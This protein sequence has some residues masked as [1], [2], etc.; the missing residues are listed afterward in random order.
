VAG[1]EGATLTMGT[2][3]SVDSIY[4]DMPQVIEEISDKNDKRA[5]LTDLAVGLIAEGGLPTLTYRSLASAANVSV[6][7]IQHEFSSREEILEATFERAWRQ[8]GLRPG[9]E[10]A[11]SPR[12]KLFEIC[13][14]AVPVE[15][16]PDPNIRAYFEL[17][18]EASRDPQ[19]KEGIEAVEL[20]GEKKYLRLIERAQEAGEIDP[21][22]DPQV[23]IDLIWSLGDGLCVAAYTY[24]ESHTPERISRLWSE[25]FEALLAPRS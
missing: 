1:F 5:R 22:H 23:L 21:N 25:G 15:E 20:E 3:D 6:G 8:A 12:A 7:S 16:P 4:A 11:D 9:E 18:F 14:R 13:S 17:I 24:P 19:L 2:T 10:E